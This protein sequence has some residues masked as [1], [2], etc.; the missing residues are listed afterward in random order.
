MASEERRAL[1]KLRQYK[2]SIGW[3]ERLRIE[4]A[5]CLRILSDTM[6]VSRL[7]IDEA[8]SHI[9]RLEEAI[10]QHRD[11]GELVFDSDRDNELYKVLEEK[12]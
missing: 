11:S 7:D 12:A 9:A 10:R 4:S 6:E 5:A 1:K 3:R 2:D 8:L